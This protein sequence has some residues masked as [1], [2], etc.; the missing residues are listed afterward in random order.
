MWPNPQETVNLVTFTEEI[1]NGKLHFL[2]IV[3]WYID[4]C[5][6]SIVILK[7]KVLRFILGFLLYRYIITNTRCMIL[8][9]VKAFK[10]L[11]LPSVV[12]ISHSP[13]F[14]NVFNLDNVFNKFFFACNLC[15]LLEK[16]IPRV[17]KEGNAFHFTKCHFNPFHSTYTSNFTFTKEKRKFVKYFYHLYC[18]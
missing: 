5:Q 4:I 8:E 7:H 18:R 14:E 2:C 12:R 13:K 6:S 10:I 1:L 17:W 16:C 3:K 9:T 11:I 15:V